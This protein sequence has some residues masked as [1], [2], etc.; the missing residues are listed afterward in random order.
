MRPSLLRQRASSRSDVAERGR[1]G[2][3]GKRE[4]RGRK[5]REREKRAP[6]AAGGAAEVV[7][8]HS[9]EIGALEMENQKLEKKIIGKSATELPTSSDKIKIKKMK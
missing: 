7:G 2:K 8:L 3:K 4:R 5:E 6:K 1:E 9:I